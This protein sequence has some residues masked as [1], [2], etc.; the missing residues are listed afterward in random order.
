MNQ[1]NFYILFNLTKKASIRDVIN[2][3]ENKI[4]K[5]NSKKLSDLD[6]KEIKKLKVALYVLTHPKLRK[7]YNKY[8]YDNMNGNSE[9]VPLNNDDIDSIDTFFKVDNQWMDN[10]DL[11]AN[12]VSKKN[13]LKSGLSDRVFSLNQYQKNYSNH[14]VESIRIP[15]QAREDK[16]STYMNT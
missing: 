8:G 12:D 10:I 16:S 7:E 15:Q 6:I 3:Y 14:D 9:P 1:E 5:F 2:S 11:S 13:Q 4:K